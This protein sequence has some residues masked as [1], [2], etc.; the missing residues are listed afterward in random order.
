[1]TAL[2]AAAL[3]A[4]TGRPPRPEPAASPPEPEPEPPVAQ[5][6]AAKP[7]PLVDLTIRA[8]DGAPIR[9]ATVL[10][11][12][13]DGEEVAFLTDAA[14]HARVP[15]SGSLSVRADGHLPLHLAAPRVAGPVE[16]TLLPASTLTVRVLDARTG[17]PIAGAKVT[18]EAGPDRQTDAQ[19]TVVLDGLAPGR[20]LLR[21]S[22]PGL[23][24][25]AFVAVGLGE[26]ATLDLPVHP[27][28]AVAG[29]VTVDDGKP[30]V[31]GS[32]ELTVGAEFESSGCP[33]CAGADGHIDGRI[34][35]GAFRLDVPADHL[36]GVELRCDDAVPDVSRPIYVA[37]ADILDLQWT[38]SRGRQLHGRVVDGEGRPIPGVEVM[39]RL[40]EV[41]TT[42]TDSDEDGRFTFGGLADDTYE[43]IA[44]GTLAGID[45]DGETDV[46]I[47]PDTPAEFVFTVITK[48]AEPDD[49]RDDDDDDAPAEVAAPGPRLRG[50]VRDARGAPVAGALV[51]LVRD[52][53]Q[54][55][56]LDALSRRWS[57]DVPDRTDSAGVFSIPAPPRR[58]DDDD[59]DD[60]PRYVALA[61][62]LGGQIGVTHLEDPA[63]PLEIVVGPPATITGSVRDRRGRPVTHFGLDLGRGRPRPVYIYTPTGEFTLPGL[64]PGAHILRIHTPEADTGR[65]ISAAPGR[66]S[67]GA[68]F[69]L[70]G[71]LHEL[72]VFLNDSTSDV[73][74]AG[75][76]VLVGP[77]DAPRP[78][79]R[80]ARTTDQDGFVE[81]ASVP[82]GPTRVHVPACTVG[83]THY[84]AQSRYAALRS[85][86]HAVLSIPLV[87]HPK[88]ASAL[89]GDLGFSVA[90]VDPAVDPAMV[91]P[92]VV[93]VRPGGAAAAAGLVV[94]DR[95]LRVDGRGVTGRDVA[96]FDPLLKVRRGAE[97]AL[98]L[99][100]GRTLTLR[101]R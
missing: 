53:P 43:L 80:S 72:A 96:L 93:R 5:P 65:R 62:V 81:F 8:I 86:G 78:A 88:P 69:E 31:S 47:G 71:E 57:G 32:I 15:G 70:R 25:D 35:D 4:C 100:G 2:A 12:P 97:V 23:A 48:P 92:T 56:T 51:Q 1:M 64:V 79:A 50:V 67:A 59:D 11:D 6:P 7:V 24:G 29:R 99:A 75:C 84:P 94:G 52:N 33:V 66:T 101:A 20:R 73:D 22:V 95:I 37:R 41:V 38:L 87:G 76:A 42:Q 16:R 82:S 39:L 18:G 46:K 85:D 60:G 14:G 44:F 74:V 17:A 19:G 26:R 98:T 40:E 3:L 83:D 13:P 91:V 34:V 45:Y 90:R 63:A 49:D 68:P 77:A 55:V 28:I 54:D 10:H 89:K 30:C 21:A 61:H 27:M 58:D 36:Y 9:G